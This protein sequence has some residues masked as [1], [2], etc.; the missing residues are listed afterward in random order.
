MTYKK[1][2]KWFAPTDDEVGGGAFPNALG[3][4][5]KPQQGILHI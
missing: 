3:M 1:G 4:D 2:N 5:A